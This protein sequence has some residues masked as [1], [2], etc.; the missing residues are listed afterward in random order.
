MFSGHGIT[1]QRVMKTE[2]LPLWSTALILGTQQLFLV[3]MLKQIRRAWWEVDII[4]VIPEIDGDQ[5][6][7][8]HR[9][10]LQML[11]VWQLFLWRTMQRWESKVQC[12]A[13]GGNGNGRIWNTGEVLKSNLVWGIALKHPVFS[14]CCSTLW[15]HCTPNLCSPHPVRNFAGL[16]LCT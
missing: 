12:N 2:S 10:P 3:N 13:K 14:L 8:L 5:S 16:L 7:A 4:W 11:G 15:A 9:V 1:Q 6:L